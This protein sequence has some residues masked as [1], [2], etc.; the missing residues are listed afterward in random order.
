MNK[1]SVI[2]L[3]MIS[4]IIGFQSPYTYAL[5][6]H[7]AQ[8]ILET[9]QAESYYTELDLTDYQL[10]EAI[11]GE[12]FYSLLLELSQKNLYFPPSQNAITKQKTITRSDAAQLIYQYFKKTGDK[13]DTV[14]LNYKDIKNASALELSAIKWHQ[15]YGIMKGSAS[16]FKGNSVLTIGEGVAIMNQL[17]SFLKG[18]DIGETAKVGLSQVNNLSTSWQ[19]MK[20]QNYQLQVSW[21]EKSTGGYSIVIEKSEIKD[22]QLLVYLKLKSP[23]PN[24]LVTQALTY[25]QANLDKTFTKAQTEQLVIQLIILK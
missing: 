1:K 8:P 14:K 9:L 12:A 18:S 16:T 20:D 5:D 21:G 11:T 15:K 22:Q 19:L 7:W 6:G 24:D 2:S 17:K 13:L 25:P 4:A 10:S 3:V 23:G